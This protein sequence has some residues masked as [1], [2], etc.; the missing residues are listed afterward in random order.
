MYF[1]I[2]FSIN[3]IIGAEANASTVRTLPFRQQVRRYNKI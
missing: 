2:K 3:I 1:I